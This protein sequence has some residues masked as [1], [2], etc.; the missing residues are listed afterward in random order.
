MTERP[1]SSPTTSNLSDLAARDLKKHL[2]QQALSATPEVE[3]SEAIPEHS[4][5]G[6]PAH[7][8]PRAW[9]LL[10]VAALFLLLSAAASSLS[11]NDRTA[12]LTL[13]LSVVAAFVWAIRNVMAMATGTENRSM[14]TARTLEQK[15]ASI[16]AR[17]STQTEPRTDATTS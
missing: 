3:E 8:M 15:L 10:L 13:G 9:H 5:S 11:H 16:Q 1:S 2:R 4:K 12:I 14:G 17:R 6:T 7:F